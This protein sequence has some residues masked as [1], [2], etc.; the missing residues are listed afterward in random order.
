[1][2]I[3]PGLH[4]EYLENRFQHSTARTTKQ[5]RFLIPTPQ[6]K[7][8]M[9][10]PL[11]GTPSKTWKRII[12]YQKPTSHNT[13]HLSDM[14]ANLHP[15]ISLVYICILHNVNICYQRAP[16][17]TQYSTVCIVR[18][19]HKQNRTKCCTLLHNVCMCGPLPANLRG[20]SSMGEREEREREK[21]REK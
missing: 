9:S 18:T 8:T 11:Y 10:S 20:K 16:C 13:Y 1:M 3:A 21:G 7:E 2:C 4:R 6:S 5:K 17:N 15:H 12:C 14:S 19:T